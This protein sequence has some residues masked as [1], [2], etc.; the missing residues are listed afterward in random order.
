[1]IDISIILPVYNSEKTVGK[2]LDCAINQTFKNW[3]LL[4]IDDGSTDSTYKICSQYCCQDKRIKVFHKS[5]GGVASARQMG[6]ELAIG[7]YSIQIDSD[8]WFESSMLQA[9]YEKITK[10]NSDVI[11]ADFYKCLPTGK[12][13]KNCQNISDLSSI[14]V[15]YGILVGK[16]F[17]ALWNKL[18]RHSLYKE[19]NARFFR[20]I[21]YMEDVLIWVQL[22]K[23]TAV[24][25]SYLPE[26]FYHYCINDKSITQSIS[27]ETFDGI[28]RMHKKIESLLPNIDNRFAEYKESLCIGEFQAGFLNNLFTKSETKI[29][30]NKM[31]HLAC[32][33]PSLRWKVGYFLIQIGAYR[34]AYLLLHKK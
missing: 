32:R 26:A 29:Y 34:L 24:R 20:G 13:F 15:L 7:T 23:H 21:N 4:V 25:I 11:I 10:D 12:C 27:R 2:V 1:M 28:V 30:Y 5:N 3:E 22:L 19:F 16:Y 6:I 8:D 17:G 33:N 18:V 9:M 14:D 31:R